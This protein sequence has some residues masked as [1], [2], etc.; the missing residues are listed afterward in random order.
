MVERM[1]HR[2]AAIAGLPVSQLEG[3]NMVRYTPGEYFT[4][5]HD[6]KFRP[7]TVFVYLND[8]PDDDDGETYFSQI[9]MKFV[10]RS[11]TAVVWS[12]AQADGKE[13]SRVLHEG[14]P[15]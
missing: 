12:N 10:P 4:E 15:P 11:C 13:D 5:H 8:L 9:G 3:L 6:G 2:F 14:I 1:E 7:K